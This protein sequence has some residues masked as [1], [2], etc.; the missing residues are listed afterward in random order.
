M[1]AIQPSMTRKRSVWLGAVLIGVVALLIVKHVGKGPA[2]ALVPAPAAFSSRNAHFLLRPHTPILVDSAS[3]TPAELLKQQ[4]ESSTGFKLKVEQAPGRRAVNGAM[5][6][7]TEPLP[8][9]DSAEGYE[10]TVTSQ[11]VLLRAASSAGIFYGVQSLLQLMPPDVFGTVKTAAREE[12]PVQ[13]VTIR[14]EPRF[15]WRG[16]LLDVARH[17]FT[18]AEVKQVAD[19]LAMHKLNRFQLHLTDDQGWRIEIKR[20]PK[21]TEV[22]AWRKSIGFKL[23][24]KS[25]TAYAPDGRYGGFYTQAQMKEILAYA[26]ARNITLVPEIE[27]PGHASAAL[28]AYP[29]LSCSGGPYNTDL[30][31]GV[32]DGVFCAGKEE[33]FTFLENVLS[34]V[35]EVFPGKFIHLGGDEVP[36]ENWKR[37]AQCQARMHAEGLKSEEEL[38]SYFI[39]R[40][41]K[42]ITSRGR[43][44][45]GWSEILEGGLAPNAIVMDWIGGAVEAATN[46]HDVVM[47]PTRFCYLDYYQSTNRS[48]EPAAMGGYL[49]LEKVYSFEPVPVK[50]PRPFDKHILGA[51]GNLW[52]EYIANPAHAQYMTFPRLTALAEV[53]WSPK[54]ARDYEDFCRRL[55]VQLK[56]FQAMGLNYRKPEIVPAP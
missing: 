11:G 50:L 20:Y 17:F 14:D 41:E 35:M 37:C 42:F 52:T 55:R 48:A 33:T 9:L 43:R 23:D 46:G 6:M 5:V 26:E 8:A 12:W 56:R 53:T 3:A 13:C 32:Y 39:R 25:S 16:Y 27:V 49:P 28:A 29:E 38:Q 51:Q 36:K 21:L 44:M 31:G 54:R 19:A 30:E 7:V 34:E 18:V 2:L 10:L 47:S 15:Q 24:P 4:L 1:A 45:V 40:L 22:G